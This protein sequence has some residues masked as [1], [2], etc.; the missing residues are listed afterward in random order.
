MAGELLQQP[1]TCAMLLAGRLVHLQWDSRVF[2]GAGIW[3]GS[4]L[5]CSAIANAR[6]WVPGVSGQRYMPTA[7]RISCQCE[8][9]CSWRKNPASAAPVLCL[10]VPANSRRAGFSST[11][12]HSTLKFS[13][14]VPCSILFSLHMLLL[15]AFCSPPLGACFGFFS[16]RSHESL[17]SEHWSLQ[18][19]LQFFT[20]TEGKYAKQLLFC[21]SDTG[22][23]QWKPDRVYTAFKF[24]ASCP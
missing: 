12:H 7:W 3:E 11:I 6:G 10:Q 14:Q 16:P 23:I 8:L 18:T 4:C 2:Q 15:L 17:I 9:L 19:V 21:S 13:F 1:R 20:A 24:H 5:R 22:K